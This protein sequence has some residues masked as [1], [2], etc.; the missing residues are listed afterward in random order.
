MD[1]FILE[2]PQSFVLCGMRTK[3]A[4]VITVTCMTM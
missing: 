2:H 3:I 1:V 4:Y